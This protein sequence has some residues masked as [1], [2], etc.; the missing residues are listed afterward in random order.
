MSEKQILEALI[1][2]KDFSVCDNYKIQ[3]KALDIYFCLLPYL[4]LNQN[5]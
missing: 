3:Y 5:D 4:E 1:L 2:A